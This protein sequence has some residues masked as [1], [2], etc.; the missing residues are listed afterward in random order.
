MSVSGQSLHIPDGPGPV[1]IHDASATTL[2]HLRGLLDVARTVRR[3]PALEEVMAAVARTVSETLGFRTVV[4]NLY[5]PESDDYRVST[6]HGSD[7]ARE[8]LLGKVTTRASWTPLLDPAFLRRG[9]YHIP[10]GTFDWSTGIESYV[11]A[12]PAP[13]EVPPDAAGEAW[14][15]DDAIFVTL[16]GPGGR[17]YGIISVDEPISR[18]RPDDQQLDVLSA[19]AAH[20]A[21]AIES[22][23]QVAALEYAATRNEAVI[24]A[25]LDGIIALDSS[26][27]VIEFNPAAER[28]LGYARADV[29]GRDAVDLLALADRR[30][31]ARRVLANC[32]ADCEAELLGRHIETAAIRADGT[33]L[34]VELSLTRVQASPDDAPVLYAF[35]RDISERRRSQEQLTYLAYHDPLTGLPNRSQIERH[36]EMALAR[37]ER[38]GHAVALMFAD[39]DDFK[40]VNDRLGHAAGDRLLA[41]VA[42]RLRGKL[43]ATDVLGRH[44]GDEF[45]VLL[46][47]LPGDPIAKAETVASNL[48]GALR[49]PFVIGSSEVKIGGS[50]GISLYPQD[51]TDTEALMRHADVAMY[52]AKSHGG[53]R[54]AFH[55]HSNT[56]RAR[57]ASLPSQL[58]RALAEDEFVLHYQPV[59][60]L[61]VQGG[62]IAGLEALVRWQHPE[63]GL[64]MP[65]SF[66]D[67]AEESSMGDEL[68]D[69]VARELCRQASEWRATGLRPHVSLNVSPHQLRATD[70]AQRLLGQIAAHRL[71]PR[72]F[73]VELTESA[74]TIDALG[75]LS[76]IETLRTAGVRLAIDDFGAGWS[77]LRR[78][79][80]LHFDGLKIDRELL[81]DV[82]SDPTAVA[83]MRAV[84]DLARACGSVF[85][86]EG[87]ETEEQRQF[88]ASCGVQLAQGF[89]LARPQPVEG[90]TALLER[91]LVADRREIPVA[92][93]VAA[94]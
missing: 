19:F 48:L 3:E 10:A 31:N 9:V 70:F 53:G 14:D 20:T 61:G 94:A 47:D 77:S 57:Q 85:V 63:L 93:P 34:P 21:L 69:W 80:Q 35:L 51:A 92:W 62:G 17:R 89:H 12:S 79:R 84:L 29:V 23:V 43:R 55:K 7:E 65:G 54:Y 86:V 76:A 16:E 64:L 90:A 67:A 38:N 46:T 13:G 81:R 39:L 24:E 44:G 8:V 68:A 22:A 18:R 74:W 83:V 50:V 6:V 15:P 88:L 49:E 28:M 73:V 60:N 42:D 25:S 59:W 5:R 82:P 78:L 58:R 11:P 32:L 26:C 37:A 45:L 1:P 2:A 30:D 36:L 66:I 87:V 33:E 72:N 91:F 4:V 75:T 27:Q 71:D 52:A 41:E 56:L 40:L